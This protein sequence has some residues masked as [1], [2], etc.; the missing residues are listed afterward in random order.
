MKQ[1]LHEILT[2][3]HFASALCRDPSHIP[4]YCRLPK[5]ITDSRKIQQSIH[6]SRS[7]IFELYS[8]PV[9]FFL[10]LSN[11]VPQRSL[12]YVRSGRVTMSKYIRLPTAPRFDTFS[13]NDS[14]SAAVLDSPTLRDVATEF[15][16]IKL[17]LLRF[18]FFNI[19][20]CMYRPLIPTWHCTWRCYH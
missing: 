1:I 14:T 20:I 4:H 8:L 12:Y 6:C 7:R 15:T 3:F 17:D 9:S 2:S 19:L 5:T 18:L 16:L 13:F 10:V 11:Y